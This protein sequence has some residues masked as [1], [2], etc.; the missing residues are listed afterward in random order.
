MGAVQREDTIPGMIPKRHYI[1]LGSELS[2]S[3]NISTNTAKIHQ[4]KKLKT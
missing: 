2:G 4:T 3:D 1:L